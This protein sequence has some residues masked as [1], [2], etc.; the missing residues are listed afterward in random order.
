[1]RPRS[2]ERSCC[3]R[4]NLSRCSVSRSDDAYDRSGTARP[5]SSSTTSVMFFATGCRTRRTNGASTASDAP[6]PNASR[7]RLDAGGVGPAAK[8]SRL[9]PGM[10]S[11]R[12]RMPRVACS[13]PVSCPSAT[14]CS[15]RSYRRPGRAASTSA[16]RAAGS[17]FNS[18]ST[19]TAIRHGCDR[20]RWPEAIRQAGRDTRCRKR[21][22][23]EQS[24]AA[25]CRMNITELRLGLFD[26]GYIPLPITSP[27]AP[28][29]DAGKA[30]RSVEV[31]D[32]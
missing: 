23:S 5:R 22:R 14:G 7:R 4:R 10:T 19:P 2:V 15:R 16:P 27:D 20:S 9:A 17:G 3:V 11:A 29:K 32:H 12:C 30:P 8:C 24:R 31:A 6:W 26:H 13:S 1:M 25:S 21:P 28:G 18:C